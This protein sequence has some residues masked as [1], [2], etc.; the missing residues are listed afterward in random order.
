MK[1]YKK[2]AAAI[3]AG[4]ALVSMAAC[5]TGSGSSS[6]ADSNKITVAWWG[7]QQRNERQ[8]KVNKLFEAAN[9][10]VTVEGQF[11]EWDDYW[12][13]L[14]TNAA[15]N[16][17]PDVVAMDYS[18]LQQ[19]IDNGLLVDLDQ[20]IKDG[21]IDTSNIDDNVL[22][23]GKIDGKTYALSLGNSAPALIYNKTLTDKAGITVPDNMTVDQFIDISKQV[24]EKTGVKTNFRYYEASELLEYILRGEGKQLFGDGKL[25][26]SEQDVEDYLNVYQQGV[27]E[28]WHVAPEIFAQIK[29]GSVE[30]DPLVY[31]TDNAARS[32]CSFKFNS[33]LNAMQ[34]VLT[35]GTELAMTNWP[36]ADAKKAGYVKPSMFFV[37]TKSSK[38]PKL[39]AKYIDFYTNNEDAVK[40]MLTDRGLPVNSKMMDAI[41][42]SLDEGDQ[43]SVAYLN[44]VV[45]P[46]SS[47]INPPAPAGATEVNSTL[48]PSIEEEVLYGKKDA[49]TAAK[50]FVEQ[51]NDA[52]ASAK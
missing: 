49:A 4:A 50:E 42:S 1:A 30:Q 10:G 35:D 13:K 36:S 9:K 12:K 51:A 3:A 25:G 20:Y 26:A 22:S 21:T 16:K 6:K 38:N 23:A 29:A 15:G 41:E 47:A 2:I 31:G 52:L 18:Y 33:Q 32:W 27:K 48:L 28:G 8:A 19:Y 17:M 44:D 43:K 5:G 24:Y 37:I 7:N 40:T 34:A 11:S 39:A 46:N 14:S 45:I